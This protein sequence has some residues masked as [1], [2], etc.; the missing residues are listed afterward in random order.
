MLAGAVAACSGGSAPE[1]DGLSDQVATVG[2]ELVVYIEGS[3]ADGDR[4]T[5]G[6]DTEISLQGNASISQDPSGRGVFRWTPLAEDVGTHP[7]D[8]TISDTSETT[9]VS[10]SI[11]VRSA[12]GAVPIFRQPLGAGTAANPAACVMVDILIEDQD[13][14]QVTILEEPPAIS[15]AQFME[16]DGTSASWRWCPTPT[17]VAMQ[18]RYTLELSADDG[19]NPKTLKHYVLVLN[20][21]TPRIVINE[22]DY[23][24]IGTD[25]AEY[26]ELFNPSAVPVSLAG[27]QVVLVNGATS[28]VYDSVDLSSIGTL[29]PGRY[30]VIAGPNV[31]VSGGAMKLDPVWSQDQIQN[32]MPDGVA[33]IDGVTH[34]VIDAFSYEGA[35]ADASL[36][37]FPA[38]VSLVEGTL[39]PATVA[40]SSS[41]TRSLCRL[42]NG[43][44]TNDAATDWAA[45]GTLTPGSE[46]VP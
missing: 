15:G 24:Q 14:P 4:V 25:T 27:L 39:L 17:Q 22:V 20:S 5:Y 46:N 23:D 37:G 36:D 30:H 8:F 33:L 43:S 10:I 6:V 26:I 34:T 16:I 18:D 38:P 32:G 13:S 9:V 29:A 7:F 11:E 41:V 31:S 28:V 45:C 40:D 42:P 35:I 3:D 2:A 21:A 12:L 19:D 44:D 1:I